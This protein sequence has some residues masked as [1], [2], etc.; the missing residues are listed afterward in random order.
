MKHII[1]LMLILF[2]GIGTLVAQKTSEQNSY[3]ILLK[4]KLSQD[5][6]NEAG[7]NFILQTVP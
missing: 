5:S 4:G 7:Q 1:L 6:E 2:I 3:T